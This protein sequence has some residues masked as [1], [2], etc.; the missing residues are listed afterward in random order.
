MKIL[1]ALLFTLMTSNV[2]AAVVEFHIAPGTGANPW[3]TQE[4]SIHAKIGDTI[5][6][7]NDD[8]EEHILHTFGSPCSHGDD[9]APGASWDCK[10]LR[11]FSA[12]RNG[13]LYDHNHG[14]S[15]A[16]WIE[17]Q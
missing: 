7:F 15:A 11:A 13:P 3:N 9:F 8:S 12:E 16:V 17:V 5:R 1:S 4:T 6:F 2:F 10:A 14:Q